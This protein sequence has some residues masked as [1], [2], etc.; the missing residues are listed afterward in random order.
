MP[1]RN[2]YINERLGLGSDIARSAINLFP[3]FQGG[4]SAGQ[5]FNKRL[6]EFKGGLTPFG[7]KFSGGLES[8][9]PPPLITGT[10]RGGDDTT[11]VVPPIV[12]P[13]V[14]P[15]RPD[16]PRR[17]D[18]PPRRRTPYTENLQL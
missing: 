7:F 13:F 1:S 3:Q 15:E 17:P 2:D 9:N 11:T 16:P 8:S 14:T 4:Q 5:H 10:T 18:P 6:G 12:P